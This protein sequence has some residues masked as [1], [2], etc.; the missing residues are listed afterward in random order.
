MKADEMVLPEDEQAAKRVTV[1]GW[2]ARDGR[3]YGDDERLARWVGATHVRCSSCQQ[4]TQKGWTICEACRREKRQAKYDAREIREWDGEMIYSERTDD[5]YGDPDEA[6]DAAESLE[7]PADE[8]MLLLCEP[9]LVREL[10][11]EYWDDD[12]PGEDG[13]APGWLDEAIAAF[14]AAVQGKTLSWRPGKYAMRLAG[15]EGER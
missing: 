13:E 7:I 8:M 12:L 3:F 10:T 6:R 11:S 9:V 15:R 14:N 1:T 4:P 5:Y 2:V